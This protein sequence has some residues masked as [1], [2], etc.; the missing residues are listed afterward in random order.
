[1]LDVGVTGH[2]DDRD[3]ESLLLQQLEQIEP[4]ELGH[5]VVGD[6]EIRRYPGYRVHRIV[7]AGDQ[8]RVMPDLREGELEDDPDRGLVIHAENGCHRRYE[9]SAGQRG[10]TLERKDAHSGRPAANIAL[11]PAGRHFKQKVR[12]PPPAIRWA[13]RGGIAA[14]RLFRNYLKWPFGQNGLSASLIAPGSESSDT[15]ALKV[16]VEVLEVRLQRGCLAG[17][18]AERHT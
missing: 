8:Q 1:M 4:V 6:H 2:D 13:I 16:L 9:E 15:C 7:H 18:V 3:L 17:D 11:G 12:S 10:G 5:G 14:D